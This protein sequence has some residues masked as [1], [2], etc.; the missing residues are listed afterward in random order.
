[1]NEPKTWAGTP[2]NLD[3][4]IHRRAIEGNRVEFKATWDDQIEP[5]LVATVS[6]FANDLLNLNGGYV[7][8]GIEEAEG[9]P[10]LPPR[11][12]DDLNL[13]RVQQKVLEACRRI[14]PTYMPRIFVEDYQGR[15]I[16]VVWAPGGDT[17]PYQAPDPRNKGQR[18]YFVRQ[19]SMTV[20]ADGE[21]LTQL[22]ELT[23]KVPFDDLRNLKARLEDISPSLVRRFL[24]LVRSDLVD[25]GPSIPDYDLYRQLR[26]VT[27]INSHE[28]PINVALLFFSEDPELFF[29]G[30]RIEVV[31]FRDDAGGDLLDEFSFRGPLPDQISSALRFLRSIGGEKV[32][33]VPDQA[34]AIRVFAYPFGAVEEALVNAAYHRGYD[35]PAEPIK[36]YIYP[37]RMEI[38]SYPGPV[39]G[40]SREQL[41]AGGYKSTAPARNRRIGDFLKELRMAEARGT[42]IP[43]IRRK[44]KENGSPE[45]IF[46]FD[47]T[48]TYYRTILPIHPDYLAGD[49]VARLIAAVA[50]KRPQAEIANMVVENLSDRSGSYAG[51]VQ[52]RKTFATDMAHFLEEWLLQ[53]PDVEEREIQ[54]NVKKLVE[55]LRQA[56]ELPVGK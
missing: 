9:R 47:D 5:A 32:R 42:G 20:K 33:K 12:L 23:A 22:M 30:A 17:R 26:L 51:Y 11:G 38:I 46:D 13:E 37:D 10:I 29:P 35:G 1:M 24:H 3:D 41:K 44:M 40:L 27:P 25:A 28:V 6:A 54:D 31:Q 19:G 4:L 34:E 18:H 53:Q 39:L 50:E 43:K 55:D 15:A 14:V 2:F 21:I 36:V 56:S 45:P 48:R 8:L 52:F 16:A 49:L 7:V